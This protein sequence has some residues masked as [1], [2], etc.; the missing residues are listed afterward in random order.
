[1]SASSPTRWAQFWFA[2]SPP[3]ELNSIRRALCVVVAIYFASAL[4]DVTTWLSRGA[5]ASSSNLA[6][7]FRTAELTSDA[8]WMVSPLFVWDS[9][10]G[11][12]S[13]GESATIYRC[14]L[15]IGIALSILVGVS[16]RLLRPGM[17][18]WATRL[19]RSGL[20][21]LILWVWFVGWANRI[22]LLAGIVEPILSLS[23]AALAI[24]PIA[25]SHF[26]DGVS[27]L[28]QWRTTLSRRLLAVQAT[29]IAAL[30]TATM[31]ASPTW[32]NGTGAY[33]IVAPEQDRLVTTTDTFFQTPLVYELTTVLIVCLLPIGILLAWQGGSDGKTRPIGLGLVWC[34]CALVGFLSANLLYAA[35]MGIIAAAIGDPEKNH[36]TAGANGATRLDG[37]SVGT[38]T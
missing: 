27:E 1:M 17:P 7:F 14:Y 5:P 28:G 15:L 9:I 21:T 38:A 22:V 32:W 13:L 30:T 16:D 31:L 19:L 23:L 2:P 36:T 10:F 4:P 26:G 33:A 25:G 29:L 24:A 11:S 3:A 12:S 20:P 35:T 8:R 34:W 37:G 6:T 18:I